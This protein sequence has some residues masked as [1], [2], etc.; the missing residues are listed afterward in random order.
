MNVT[1]NYGTING[2]TVDIM[3]NMHCIELLR[4]WVKGFIRHMTENCICDN[5]V[6]ISSIGKSNAMNALIEGLKERIKDEKT[7]EVFIDH[8]T[9]ANWRYE[10]IRQRDGEKAAFADMFGAEK[11]EKAELLGFFE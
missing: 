3:P 6:L 2:M 11:A 4:A 8:M 10:V 1:V 9:D 7:L 5:T